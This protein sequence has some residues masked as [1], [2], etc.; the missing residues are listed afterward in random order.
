M[1][2]SRLQTLA[3]EVLRALKFLNPD[4]MRTYFTKG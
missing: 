1:K 3:V 4:F 2:L